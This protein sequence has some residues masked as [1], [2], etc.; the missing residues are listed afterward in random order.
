M[1]DTGALLIGLVL[2]ILAIRFNEANVAENIPW[3]IASAPAVS[4]GILVLPLFDTLRVFILRMYRGD[5]PFR[6]DKQHLH[7]RLLRLGLSHLQSTLILAGFNLMFIVIAFL[8]DPVGILPLTG[9]LLV[10][11]ILLCLIPDMIYK[12]KRHNGL[13]EVQADLVGREET[14]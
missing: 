2:A 10:L 7:H 3:H 4:I 6:A 5:S 9:I 13:K 14:A 12:K 11:A 8:L 1:G